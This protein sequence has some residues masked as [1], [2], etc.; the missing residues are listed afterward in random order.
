MNFKSENPG[1][2]FWF[3]EKDD[4]DGGVCLRVLSIDE[5][6]RI[7]KITTTKKF[8]PIRGQVTEIKTVDEDMRDRLVWDYCI[9]GWKDIYLDGKLLEPNAENKVAMMK[10]NTFAT[11]FLD[12]VTELN[13]EH[14]VST[15]L[16]EKNSKT[17]SSGSTKQTAKTA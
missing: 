12:K 17:S 15:E 14:E 4:S 1:K 13:E 6:R 7:D 3:N 10:S 2:W 9:V 8:K 5:S 11:F 16:S